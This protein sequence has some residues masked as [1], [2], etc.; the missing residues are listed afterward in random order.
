MS[1]RTAPGNRETEAL[2]PKLLTLVEL[3]EFLGVSY[4]RAWQLQNEGAI[5]RVRF[6]RTIRFDPRDLAAEISKRK[7]RGVI[8]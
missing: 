1:E 3:A 4:R 5:P 2:P 7:R 6:G 8:G